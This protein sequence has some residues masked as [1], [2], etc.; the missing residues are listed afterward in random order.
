MQLEE[1]GEPIRSSKGGGNEGLFCAPCVAAGG[2]AA[3]L[4]NRRT[5][6]G[7]I[8]NAGWHCGTRRPGR[9][10]RQCD[11]RRSAARPGLRSRCQQ[12]RQSAESRPGRAFEGSRFKRFAA[13]E[14]NFAF[15]PDQRRRG[16][17]GRSDHDGRLAPPGPKRQLAPGFGPQQRPAHPR[18]PFEPTE[19]HGQRHESVE[20]SIGH[21]H[22][23]QPDRSRR[24]RK[25]HHHR[26]AVYVALWAGLCVHG[27]RFAAGTAVRIAR[28]AL[29][30][31]F[32][33]R[34]QRPNAVLARQRDHR[35][36]GLGRLRQ[37]R[38]A[39]RQRLSHWRA[40]RIPDSVAL[41]KMGR[42]AR[43]ELRPGPVFARRIQSAAHRNERR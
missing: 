16:R 42:N 4:R 10:V 15:E 6:L 43:A 8:P 25:R 2:R 17:V 41:P 33:L 36:Q 21:R 27:R 19:R 3:C 11:S 9:S 5:R 13:D 29:F 1:Y 39:R 7:T 12:S 35:R 22:A 40:G 37:L 20:G 23:V 18:L 14:S 32:R 38:P 30:D 31:Q 34:Q 24:C 26:R 28:D